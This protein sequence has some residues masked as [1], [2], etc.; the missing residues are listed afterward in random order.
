MKMMLNGQGSPE[1]AGITVHRVYF[2][3]DGVLADFN[4]GVGELC[5]M[6]PPSLYEEKDAGQDALMWQEIAKVDHFYD[7]LE[8]MPGAKELF[9]AVY[10][11]YGGRCEIL[12]GVPKPKRGIL[13]AGQDKINWMRRMFPEEIKVNIVLREEK[14]NYCTGADSILIDDHA[15]SVREWCEAGGIGIMH[16]SAE[17]TLEQLRSLNLL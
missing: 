15:V 9:G 12:T 5:H 7:R 4:R 13:T 10:G 6:T 14:V 2:D 8:L 11:V 17:N 16:E 1:K 3:M